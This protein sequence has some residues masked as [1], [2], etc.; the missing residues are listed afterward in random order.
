MSE[1]RF[2][3]GQRSYVG[4]RPLLNSEVPIAISTGLNVTNR[5]VYPQPFE[6]TTR[7]PE[8]PSLERNKW[9][10]LTDNEEKAKALADKL[11][12]CDTMHEELERLRNIERLVIN[13]RKEQQ[14]GKIPNDALLPSSITS[15]LPPT[16]TPRSIPTPIPT[17]RPRLSDNITTR[18]NRA[19]VTLGGLRRK[20]TR[21]RKIRRR[22]TK[23]AKN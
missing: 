20:K 3:V 15:L 19:H 18:E 16:P 1:R 17:P 14:A 23:R 2:Y 13:M 6:G 9:T 11:K 12:E 8:T 5:P 7:F 4:Q 22:K 10:K 21:R